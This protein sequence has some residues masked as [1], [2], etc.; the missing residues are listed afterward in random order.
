MNS[1]I[2]INQHP[3]SFRI[4]KP[5]SLAHFIEHLVQLEKP[6]HFPKNIKNLVVNTRT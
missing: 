3:I 5:V 4:D 6:P 2:P 1:C